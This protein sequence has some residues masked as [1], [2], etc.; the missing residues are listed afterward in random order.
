MDKVF[1][2]KYLV[3]KHVIGDYTRQYELLMDYVLE[4]QPTNFDTTVKTD[5]CSEPNH[6][7][8]TRQFRSIYV[9]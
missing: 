1:R 5:A 9:C 3:R 7:S 4:L 2:E 8:L 6:A